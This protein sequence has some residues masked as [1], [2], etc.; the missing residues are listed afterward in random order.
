LYEEIP[1]CGSLALYHQRLVYA[2]FPQGSSGEGI[3]NLYLSDAGEPEAVNQVDNLI[4]LVR[5][6]NPITGCWVY[7]DILY[8]GKASKT[9]AINDNSDVPST[10]PLTEIDSGIGPSNANTIAVI[11]DVGAVS[12]EVSLVGHTAGLYIFDGTYRRPEISWKIEDLWSNIREIH[13]NTNNRIIYV[14]LGGGTMLIGDYKNGLD[15]ERIR[16]APWTFD[17]N[18]QTICLLLGGGAATLILGSQ[19]LA[20]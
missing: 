16:W 18:V 3:S 2:S 8:A 7:R 11:M 17:I 9:V 13:V 12:T 6:G 14:L 5:D 19:Q 20:S 1:N 10:W 15:P 4:S